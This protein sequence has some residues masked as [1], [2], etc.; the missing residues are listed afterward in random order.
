MNSQFNRLSVNKRKTVLLRGIKKAVHMFDLIEKGDH[1]L[2]AISGGK[3]SLVMLEMLADNSPWWVPHIKLDAAHVALGFPGEDERIERILEFSKQR[4]FDIN[5]VK[6]PEISEIA[7]GDN[8]KQ[9]PCFICSRMRRKALLETV[10]KIGANKI[11]L[12]HHREDVLETFLINIFFGREIAAMKPNQELFGG[13][14]H[15]IRPMYL[16]RESQIRSLSIELNYPEITQNC[17]VAGATKREY[18]KKLINQLERENPG[19]KANLFRS[20]FHPKTDYLL[21][22]YRKK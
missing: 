21:G 18:I 1:I 4:G 3:D 14:Y 11:A 22:M 12:G 19:L 8:T 2:L 20:L 10:E 13:K 9:N 16:L 15:L 17:P 7:F 6:R 5:I